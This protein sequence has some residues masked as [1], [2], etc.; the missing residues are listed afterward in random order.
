MV[1]FQKFSRL[2][3]YHCVVSTNLI[4]TRYTEFQTAMGP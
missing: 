4:T 3:I 1:K 2:K